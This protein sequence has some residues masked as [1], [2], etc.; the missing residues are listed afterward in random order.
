MNWWES[1]PIAD[2][3]APAAAPAQ[4][5]NWWESAPVAEQPKAATP[6]YSPA[7]TA[8]MSGFQGMTAGLSD[9]GSALLAAPALKA[10][11]YFRPESDK[12]F[13][14][15]SLADLYREARDRAR[16]ANKDSAAQN[17]KTA[18]VA[19]IG[20][21]IVSPLNK[22]GSTGTQIGA[23]QGGANAFGRS[24]ADDP[25]SLALQTAGGAA[26][27]AALGFVFDKVAGKLMPILRDQTSGLAVTSAQRESLKAAQRSA[28]PTAPVAGM[29]AEQL[30]AKELADSYGVRLSSGDV[31]Q[32]VAQQR[33]EEMALR[34]ALGQETQGTAQAFRAGQ[35]GD[36]RNMVSATSQKLG[37]T[38]QAVNEADVATA[39]TGKLSGMKAADEAAV[40][41]AYK[42]AR[43][44]GSAQLPVQALAP[45]RQTVDEIRSQFPVT[46][47]NMAGT[48]AIIDDVEKFFTSNPA[49]GRV[50][51][52][53]LDDFRVKI[54][55]AMDGATRQ[56]Q[57]ALRQLKGRMQTMVD[58]AIEQ[59]LV[60]GNEQAILK[61][62]EATGLAKDYFTRWDKNKAVKQ[63]MDADLAPEQV[64]QKLV[65]Y[66]KLGANKQA[67]V[68]V[69][70]LKDL[71]GDTSP[72]WQ[73]LKAAGFWRL[74]GND[75]Q[76]VAEGTATAKGISGATVV[77]NID[78]FLKT[79]K[80]L[81]QTLFTPDEL[82]II[83][84]NALVAQ[85]ATA[86]QPGAT[87]PSGTSY[88]VIDFVNR[89]LNRLGPLGQFA[90][91]MVNKVPE[92]TRKFADRQFV[93]QSFE[94]RVMQP[95]QGSV[96]KAIRDRLMSGE[97]KD[98]GRL[99]SLLADETSSTPLRL[100]IT[101]ADK[102]QP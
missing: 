52:K 99:K 31:T 95:A 15:R 27:G 45:I 40:N 57:K 20:G 56:D 55:N 62:R 93:G 50:N 65:G 39:L 72:E 75:L 10:M 60:V 69:G 14:D 24:E 77:K 47:G 87:N 38:P 17:P 90:G 86:R 28:T 71:L 59:N 58:D 76:G 64:V 67:G 42:L 53:V 68:T 80:T 66:G 2:A 73:Q 7:E 41:Q 61:L 97:I 96:S 79:N 36:L 12:L 102:V 30:A 100:T 26:G 88:A 9:E 43:E 18:L 22:L 8:A 32:N 74:V 21:A 89:T 34:G 4:P 83:R 1:A 16:Q 81:A 48:K 3:A 54:N 44:Q 91:S 13:K 51:Y 92:A 70:Y 46:S 35:Q 6:Q 29:T 37:G 49:E 11:D 23:I 85:R 98:G 63:I 25:L 78:D 94:G 82:K 19:D 84:E 33:A 101:P 5:G